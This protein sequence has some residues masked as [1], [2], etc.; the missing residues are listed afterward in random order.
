VRAPTLSMESSLSQIDIEHAHSRTPEQVRQA[1]EGIAAKLQERHGLSSRWEGDVLAL[2]GPG[3][4]G[5]IEML[6]GKVRVQAE[7]GFLFSALQG[8]VESEIRRVL[9]EKLD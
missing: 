5:R 6:P 2:G 3:I 8:M 7:L 9:A 1:V 4:D